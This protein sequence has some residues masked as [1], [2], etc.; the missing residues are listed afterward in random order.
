MCGRLG[1]EREIIIESNA[2]NENV[3]CCSSS[4]KKISRTNLSKTI[5][6]FS[7]DENTI[8]LDS[9]RFEGRRGRVMNANPLT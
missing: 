3:H 1:V 2:I 4:D 8:S 6:C 7:T 5:T 9:M